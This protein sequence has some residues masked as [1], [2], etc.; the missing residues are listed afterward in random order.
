MDFIIYGAYILS[1]IIGIKEN[2]NRDQIIDIV[3]NMKI[4]DWV[5]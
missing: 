4:L 2:L 3:N 1:Q 5:T